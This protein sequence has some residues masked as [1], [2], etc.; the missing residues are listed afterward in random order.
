M[1]LVKICGLRTVEH[2]LAA[3]DA[4]ADL[5]GLIFAP[6]R[7]Q[8]SPEAAAE[9]A[10]AVRSSPRGPDVR[11][12]GVFVNEAPARIA[13]LAETCGLDA[14]QLSGDEDVS[15][16]RELGGRGR[17]VL[18]AVRL[19]GAASEQGWLDEPER[20]DVRLHVDAHVPGEYG[21]AGV[22]GDWVRA[23]ELARLRPI[24]LAGG[25]SP[26][27]VAQAIRQVQPWAV[28][29]S[30][31]VESSGVKDSAKIRAFVAAARSADA[32]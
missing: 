26:A 6:A 29:V 8:V 4:G 5:L 16:L 17:L 32:R 12:T 2:A 31:G 19:A 27:N 21:G 15:V 18:K 14:I 13:Q 11:L 10:Q 7:R 28:D 22:V 9:I 3:V 20:P 30:S 24:V 1:T 23:A 25:L